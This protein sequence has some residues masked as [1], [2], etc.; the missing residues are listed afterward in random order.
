MR[1]VRLRRVFIQ[2]STVSLQP[3]C[4]CAATVCKSHPIG[5]CDHD[6]IAYG[7]LLPGPG[8][9]WRRVT[10]SLTAPPP[11]GKHSSR[12]WESTAPV[13]GKAQHGQSAAQHSSIA[14]TDSGGDVYKSIYYN[15]EKAVPNE[16]DTS[17]CQLVCKLLAVARRLHPAQPPQDSKSTNLLGLRCTLLVRIE[18]E[19]AVLLDL[20]RP[21]MQEAACPA[22]AALRAARN[23]PARASRPPPAASTAQPAK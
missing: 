11:V 1:G 15:T 18:I 4:Q 2:I 9:G 20:A 12:L 19:V 17:M 7:Q 10:P 6:P 21:R 22:A 13:C 16:V 8:P 3:H 14:P 23:G 5:F